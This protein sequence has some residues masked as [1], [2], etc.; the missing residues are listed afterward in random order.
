MKSGP[1]R[2]SGASEVRL[3]RVLPLSGLVNSRRVSYAARGQS[4][5]KCRCGEVALF[6][7]LFEGRDTGL[8]AIDPM[9]LLEFLPELALSALENRALTSLY[10]LLSRRLELELGLGGAGNYSFDVL[11]SDASGVLGGESVMV[12][13]AVPGWSWLSEELDDTFCGVDWLVHLYCLHVLITAT[14]AAARCMAFARCSLISADSPATASSSSSLRLE[15]SQLENTKLG[16]SIRR[17]RSTA[18]VA[19]LSTKVSKAI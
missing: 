1:G 17:T 2:G 19:T 5:L 7:P 18:S 4:T 16:K 3:S 12:D 14:R 11:R 9:A 8:Y 15:G 13:R 10:R 6:F